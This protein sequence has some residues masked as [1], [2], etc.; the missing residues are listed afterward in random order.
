RS[1]PNR[2][3]ESLHSTDQKYDFTHA[4]SLLGREEAGKLLRAELPTRNV[5]R[6]HAPGGRYRPFDL[7]GFRLS[8][9][10]AG[11]AASPRRVPQLDHIAAREMPDPIEVVCAQRAEVRVPRLADPEYL[12]AHRTAP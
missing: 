10:I 7:G 9:R 2:F 11:Q 5:E 6:H 4:G 3:V 12:D 8:Q 1:A